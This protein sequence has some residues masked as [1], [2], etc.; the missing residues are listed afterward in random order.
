MIEFRTFAEHLS[1]FPCNWAQT[2]TLFCLSTWY[3]V[4]T[5]SIRYWLKTF[6]PRIWTRMTT[7]TK[8]FVVVL[9]ANRLVFLYDDVSTYLHTYSKESGSDYCFTKFAFLFWYFYIEMEQ[10]HS[11]FIV[12][13]NAMRCVNI[14]VTMLE[15]KELYIK[16]AKDTVSYTTYVFHVT[17]KI[18]EHFSVFYSCCEYY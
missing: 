11:L 8:L 2:F 18:K 9:C 3:S 12:W 4:L 10:Y 16:W 15:S 14:T 7:T 1:D 6:S 17:M 13:Y 5:L